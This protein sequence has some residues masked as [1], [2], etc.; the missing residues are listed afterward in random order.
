MKFLRSFLPG[1]FCYFASCKMTFD[2]TC[3]RVRNVVFFDDVVFRRRVRGGR[4]FVLLRIEN[5]WVAISPK[6]FDKLEII[7]WKFFSLVL[8][9]GFVL[10]YA[11]NQFVLKLFC[12]LYIY[13]KSIVHIYS[14]CQESEKHSPKMNEFGNQFKLVLSSWNWFWIG[15]KAINTFWK[16]L[17]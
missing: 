6:C 8:E 17:R 3:W 10:N 7:F 16:F 9:T 5:G 12:K 4:F 13:Y 14:Q 1:W 15:S 11:R 2:F